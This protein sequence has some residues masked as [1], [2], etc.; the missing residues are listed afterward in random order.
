MNIYKKVEDFYNKLIETRIIY[1]LIGISI[2]ISYYL[3]YTFRSEDNTVLMAWKY[4]FSYD[5]IKINELLLVL[6][7]V[8]LISLIIS[9]ISISNYLNQEKYHILFLFVSGMFIC[10]LFWNIPEINPDAAR[11]FMEAK[12]LELRGIVSFTN[13]WGQGFFVWTDSPSVPFFYGIILK[14]LGEYRVYIQIYNAILFSLTSVLTYKISKRLWNE[15]IG[16]YSGLMIMSFPFLLSQVPL[17]L[18]DIT[19]MFLTILSVFLILKIFDNKYY[20][21]PASLAIFF[22]VYAKMSSL[23]FIIPPAISILIINYK[24]VLK[25]KNRWIFT[26]I[27]TMAIILMFFLLN[28]G[29]FIDNMHTVSN[30]KLSNANPYFESPLN[31]LFQV[32]SI[33]I[34]LALIS[35]IIAY[36][37]KDKKYLFLIIWIVL[38]LIFLYNTRIRQLISIFPVIAIM[39]SISLFSISHKPIKKFLILSL[40]LTSIAFT[41]YAYIPFEENFTDRNIK[42]AA[43]YANSLNIS[44]IELFL[45]FSE[46][47]SQDP[48]AMVSLFDIYSNK[49]IVFSGENKFYPVADFSN[50]WNAYYKIPTFYYENTSSSLSRNERIIVTISDKFESTSIPPEVLKNH[51]LIEKFE[52]RRI[53]VFF[54]SSVKIYL[55]RNYSI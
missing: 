8:I 47:H 37:N 25:D 51:V 44:E 7:I 4:V 53:S 20:S 10:T 52:G 35:V 9:R 31:F 42:D 13:D 3:L 39:A 50:Q 29:V 23:L 27:F 54:P 1:F 46:K 17:M 16:L 19:L 11:Y 40:F 36:R 24:S 21:I 2:L 22:A 41:L 15:E 34:I 43:E 38:P 26:F 55:P 32:G 28:M 14:Y 49:K 6:S 45:D 5:N 30:F 18:V 12:Y 33:V 48:E